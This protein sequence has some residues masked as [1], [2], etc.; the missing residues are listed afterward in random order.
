M[1]HINK[2]NKI[3]LLK[4]KRKKMKIL[5]PHLLSFYNRWSSQ[6]R[7]P[8]GS[9]VQSVIPSLEFLEDYRHGFNY[10]LDKA[11]S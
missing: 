3:H 7:R 4:K 1:K 2:M 10:F 11:S 9:L 8:L 6:Y 5:P